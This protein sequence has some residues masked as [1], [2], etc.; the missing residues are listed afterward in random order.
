MKIKLK[1]A[2]IKRENGVQMKELICAETLRLFSEEGYGNTSIRN[3][4]D[5][6]KY[7]PGTIYLYYKDKD[8]LLYAVQ[9]HGFI[10]LMKKVKTGAKSLHPLKRLKQICRVYI[11]FGLENPNLY[12]LMFIVRAPKNIDDT[13]HKVN[14]ESVIDYF[15]NCVSDCIRQDFLYIDNF[16]HGYLQVWSMLHGLISLNL[17]CRLK[18]LGPGEITPQTLITAIDNYIDTITKI[19]LFNVQNTPL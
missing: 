11:L 10:K 18:I 7:S 9:H 4:A 16:E 8:E 3:I 5:A 14:D 19:D 6:I 12:D 17:R 15:Q 13:Q 1:I 2:G